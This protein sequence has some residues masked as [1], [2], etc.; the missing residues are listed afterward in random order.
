LAASL[1]T[2]IQSEILTVSQNYQEISSAGEGPEWECARLYLL[3]FF[4]YIIHFTQVDVTHVVSFLIFEF[5]KTLALRPG[6]FYA[7]RE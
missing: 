5:P 1:I 2:R 7:S 6:L 3:K 4:G